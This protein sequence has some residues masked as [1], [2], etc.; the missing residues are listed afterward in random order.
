MVWKVINLA[1]IGSRCGAHQELSYLIFLWATMNSVVIH[2]HV[3]VVKVCVWCGG[4][5]GVL[6]ACGWD[7][8]PTGISTGQLT[9]CVVST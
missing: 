2:K 5:V 7:L 1:D 4:G 6:G 3:S 8:G 9:S